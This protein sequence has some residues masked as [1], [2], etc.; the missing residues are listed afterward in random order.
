MFLMTFC[1]YSNAEKPQFNVF[2]VTL[3][4]VYF[5]SIVSFYVPNVMEAWKD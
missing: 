2:Y 4:D 1:F 5:D 3:L